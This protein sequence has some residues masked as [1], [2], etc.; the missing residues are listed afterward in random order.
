V[1]CS[2]EGDRIKVKCT[3]TI[4]RIYDEI[5]SKLTGD[6]FEMGFNNRYLMDALRAAECDEVKIILNGPLSP[7]KIFP[8]DGENF[9]FLVLPVRL[10]SD[11]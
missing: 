11:E 5:P 4:G 2:F 7:M 3:T 6:Q 1:R 10:K 8:L 9:I